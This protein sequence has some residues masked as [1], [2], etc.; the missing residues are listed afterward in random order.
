[1]KKLFLITVLCSVCAGLFAGPLIDAA[2]ARDYKTFEKLVKSNAD[3]NETDE[4]GMNVQLSLAYFN[5][6]DFKKACKLLAKKGFDFDVPVANNISLVYVLAYSCAHEK[7]SVLLKYKVDVNRKNSITELKPIEAT[8]FSTFKFFSEQIIPDDAYDRAQKTRKLLLQ[9]GSDA[10]KYCDLTFGNVGN[11]FF[12]LANV[13]SSIDPFITPQE[14]NSYNL[15]DYSNFKDQT[16][17]IV[18]QQLLEKVFLAFGVGATIN[19]YYDSQEIL[20]KLI[21]CTESPYPFVLIGNT[22]NNPIAPYQ[23]VNI[24]GGSYMED[25]SITASLDTFSPDA[26]YDFVSYDVQ[27]ISQLVTIQLNYLYDLDNLEDE[28]E[29]AEEEPVIISSLH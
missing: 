17:V 13:F 25:N 15:F 9:H 18:N 14:L 26:L 29:E 20:E 23:W 21:E 28:M 19:N 12:C 16:L 8:Q 11:F 3:L 7:L 6:K 27:D 4:N 10:F 5:V 2:K 24:N 22:G 1:M